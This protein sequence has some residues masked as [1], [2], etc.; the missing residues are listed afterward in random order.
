MNAITWKQHDMGNTHR[1]PIPGIVV[2]IA[3]GKYLLAWTTT[4]AKTD[5]GIHNGPDGFAEGVINPQRR[6]EAMQLLEMF[7]ALRW[8]STINDKTM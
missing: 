8:I 4:E 6:E 1:G 2:P 3:A 5:W 7:K